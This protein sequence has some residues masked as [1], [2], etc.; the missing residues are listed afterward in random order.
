V[1]VAS[2]FVWA[3]AQAANPSQ[4]DFDACNR[5]AQASSN[6]AASPGAPGAG[7]STRP[8]AVTPGTSNAPQTTTPA[9]PPTAGGTS[10][11]STSGGG[12]TAGGGTGSS[13]V[14][15]ESLQG[16][17]SAGANDPNYQKAYRDCMKRRGF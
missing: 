8:G 12:S 1:A 4:A 2:I 16:I 6:P 14:G 15:S 9:P 3:S 7:S 10:S 17:A 11:P 13:S 5:E